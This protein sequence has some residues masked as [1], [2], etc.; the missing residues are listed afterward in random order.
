MY[1]VLFRLGSFEVS[2]FGVMV[3]LGFL[4]GGYLMQAELDRRG[5]DPE[6][7]WSL[8]TIAIVGGL[9]GARLYYLLLYWPA[10]VANPW[11]ALTAR[12]GLVWY[13]GFL[14]ALPGL[15]WYVR[16]NELSAFLVADVAAPALALGYAVGRVGCFLVGDDYGRPTDQPWGVAFP[17][18]LPPSTADALRTRF[19]IE[20]PPGVPDLTVLKV[21]P[22]QLYEVVFMVVVFAVLWRLRRRA[23]P[24]GRLFSIYLALAGLERLVVEVFRAKDDRFFG[25]FTMAQ[26]I[27][28]SSIAIAI[29]LSLLLR[30]G[31]AAPWR[32]SEPG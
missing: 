3:A 20:I 14:G 15:I 17:R 29:I 27:G 18:G 19:A 10:T 11:G 16:R 8:I 12:G 26:V 31:G 30:S 13:G 32:G 22:T 1:P 24:P 21:H 28:V 5:H 7:A 25:D 9:L 6:H 4:I 23:W 2:S